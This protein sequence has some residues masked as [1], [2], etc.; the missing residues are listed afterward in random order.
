MK[1]QFDRTTSFIRDFS[2]SEVLDVVRRE[3]LLS[4]SELCE[5]VSVSRATVSGIVAELLAIGLLEEVGVG[6]STGGR[7][8]IKLSYRPASSKAVGIVMFNNRI[9]A[10]LTDMEG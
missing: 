4:R 5:A 1:R 8:P 6:P 7:R 10:A 3:R 2:R 9:H